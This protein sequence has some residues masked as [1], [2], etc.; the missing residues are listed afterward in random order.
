MT[1]VRA[2]LPYAVVQGAVLALYSVLPNYSSNFLYAYGFT[3]SQISLL[4]GA[5]MA[6][7]F[8]LS[9][10]AA[11]LISRIPK[12]QTYQVLLAFGSIVTLCAV[13]ML[14][15]RSKAAAAVLCFSLSFL[16]I[17]TFQ[18]LSNS[19]GM[20]AVGRGAPTMFGAARGAGSIAFCVCS[21]AAGLLT[22]RFGTAALS[23]LTL[24]LALVFLLGVVL[25]HRLVERTLSAAPA[26]PKAAP[27]KEN[28]GFLSRYPRFLLLM[29]GA[30][31]LYYSHNLIHSFMLQI[32]LVKG[33]GAV[34]Q[35]LAS[36]MAGLAE[37]PI[38][39]LF[40]LFLRRLP[41][42]KWMLL[43]G[44]FF[45]AKA[46]LSFLSPT[47]GG[48]VAA[49]VTQFLGFGLFAISSVG[50]AAETVG[51]REAVR[52]QTYLASMLTLGNLAAMA[53]GGVICQYFGAQTMLLVSAGS[54]VLGGVLLALEGAA[55][56]TE[57]NVAR[58]G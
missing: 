55:R 47:P 9:I 19:L 21:Y 51:P 37:L 22:A 15:W 43:S 11:E 23:A 28:S 53:S 34:E 6:L 10:G 29:A 46:L 58:Q 14:L 54:A 50:Y 56:R 8:G 26:A 35:G 38:M 16:V 36:S 4:L 39:F 20:D 49:M 1:K 32:M 27:E 17:E 40:P 3:D 12:L 44:L 42:R 25:F 18:A 57:K 33:G 5:A 30:A 45:A 31:L 41:N 2:T 48:V 52:A 24:A 7:S 13:G